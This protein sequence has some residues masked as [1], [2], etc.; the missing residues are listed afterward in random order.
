MHFFNPQDHI[1]PTVLATDL[2]GTLIPLPDNRQNVEDLEALRGH[3]CR[4]GIKLIYAT[5]RHFESALEAI[6]TYNLP[7]PDWLIC[8]V[9]TSIYKPEKDGPEF[10]VLE[11]YKKDL[12]TRVAGLDRTVVETTLQ[13]IEGLK[14]QPEAHQQTFK[15]SYECVSECVDNLVEV[16]NEHLRKSALPYICV[17]SVDPFMDCGLLDVMPEGVSKAFALYWLSE[18]IQLAADSILYAG[19]SGNDLAVLASGLPAIIVGNASANLRQKAVDLLEK[20]SL[21]DRLYSAKARATSGV[22]E[23]ALHFGLFNTR[24]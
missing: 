4:S 24:S 11:P 2:D 1:A 21:P 20:Q 16:A 12:T 10:H 9:G 19:D 13:P 17:G 14:R 5:G 23:G 3:L 7:K 15:I 6:R 8:D 22:L 18:H